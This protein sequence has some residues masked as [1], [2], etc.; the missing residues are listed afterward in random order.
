MLSRQGRRSNNTDFATSNRKKKLAMTI[1]VH[2][3]DHDKKRSFSKTM[4][5]N[6]LETRVL[7]IVKKAYPDLD[8]TKHIVLL[9]V[10]VRPVVFSKNAPFPEKKRADL[11][12]PPT[13]RIPKAKSLPK[14]HA[15]LPMKPTWIEDTPIIQPSKE[16]TP[17]VEPAP[18]K[19]DI[20]KPSPR[21][22]WLV[23]PNE[24]L[25]EA[26]KGTSILEWPE[27]E[28]WPEELA[29][30]EVEAERLEYIERRRTF[31]RADWKR[32]REANEDHEEGESASKKTNYL[33]EDEDS[34][35]SDTTDSET[36]SSLSS[37]DSID[38][39]E[40]DLEGDAISQEVAVPL[41]VPTILS[42]TLPPTQPLRGLASLP[43]KPP[44][45]L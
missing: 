4:H 42:T 28:I 23:E 32:K 7:D 45:Q 6:S 9:P 37:T 35:D 11:P 13:V 10:P 18:P 43:P 2:T 38:E 21:E 33:N 25:K 20:P 41:A 12:S 34:S 1:S 15:S 14:A 44:V 30:G 19:R 31:D 26:L 5:D 27:F 17:E 39:S 40:E 22:V 16:P 29:R 36:S 24:T 3:L 8:P